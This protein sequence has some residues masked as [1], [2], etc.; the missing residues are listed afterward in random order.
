MVQNWT[1]EQNWPL[2]LRKKQDQVK[3]ELWNTESEPRSVIR[4]TGTVSTFASENVSVKA[5]VAGFKYDNRQ[6]I[7]EVC[8][9]VLQKY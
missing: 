2:S 3:E 7:E 1:R 4:W 5:S 6:N 9:R 8:M